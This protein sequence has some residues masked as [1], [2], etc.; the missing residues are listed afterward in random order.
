MVPYSNYDVPYGESL[1]DFISYSLSHF[2]TRIA[3]QLGSKSISY[4]ELIN[5]IISVA[6]SFQPNNRAYILINCKNIYFYALGVYSIIISNNIVL[7]HNPSLLELESPFKKI[8]EMLVIDDQYV[9]NVLKYKSAPSFKDLPTSNLEEVCMIACSSGTTGD[10]KGV[11]LSQR[12]LCQDTIGGMEKY[13]YDVGARYINVLPYY[14]LFGIVAD[15]LGPIYSGGTIC[16]PSSQYSFF[17]ALN[18]YKP[19]VLN[20]PPIIVEHL[21][22]LIANSDC[23]ASV[24]GGE[25]RKVMCAGAHMKEKTIKFLKSKGI[26]VL[27]AYGLT[28][29]SPCISIN[30]DLYYKVGSVGVPL[31]CIEIKFQD[32]EI[33]VKGSTI[34][35]GYAFDNKSTNQKIIDGWLHTG[36][37]GYIDQDGFLYITGRIDNMIIL[38]NGTKY[39]PEYYENIINQ[40]NFVQESMI[41]PY[42][43]EHEQYL[44]VIV[45][46][47]SIKN[48]LFAINQLNK[49]KMKYR[50]PL[51]KIICV[52]QPLPKNRLGK[53]ERNDDIYAR[54]V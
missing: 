39:I 1:L 10:C 19:T 32:G 18:Q 17:S 40:L 13:K 41:F 31:D 14:H 53:V 48:K 2:R 54:F 44:G 12:N 26:L 34:M 22:H 33:C 47:D 24:T 29:C 42:K 46:I 50:L 7:L 28:E 49:I 25:L 51:G 6:N 38:S 20:A 37:L 30:R 21:A 36:D 8:D 23:V 3:F 5:D 9:E 35:I 27:C 11:K 15:L 45:V 4:E 52:T 43:N 16:I